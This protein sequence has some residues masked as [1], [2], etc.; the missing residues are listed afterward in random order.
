M[1]HIE[2]P[3]FVPKPERNIYRDA[4]VALH[5]GKTPA[6]FFYLRAFIEHF[7]RRQTGITDRRTGDEILNDYA[8]TIPEDRR[9][10]LTSLRP[11]YDQL[12]EAVHR[13]SDEVEV[14]ERLR[15]DVD[16]HFEI[17]RVFKIPDRT[18]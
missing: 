15:E 7:A 5:G 11:L 6:A 14:F 17:R 9:D 10:S 8:T 4:L 16:H 3:A 18:P 1:E 13:L 2:L 12:S